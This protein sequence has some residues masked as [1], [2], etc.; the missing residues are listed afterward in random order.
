MFSA[1][2]TNEIASTGSSTSTNM[3]AP[4]METQQ[5]PAIPTEASHERM[6]R[7]QPSFEV[8]QVDG[9]PANTEHQKRLAQ[10][11]TLFAWRATEIDASLHVSPDKT[12]T[13]NETD[14][15]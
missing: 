13:N 9:D 7:S 15:T 14:K 6:T 10:I 2:I 8:A 4:D 12:Q 5:Q 1:P 11:K 3:S